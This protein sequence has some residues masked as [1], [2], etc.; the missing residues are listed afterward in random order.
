MATTT[1]TMTAMPMTAKMTTTTTAQ[2]KRATAIR[3][4]TYDDTLTIRTKTMID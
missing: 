3:A 1:T 2:N 4:G